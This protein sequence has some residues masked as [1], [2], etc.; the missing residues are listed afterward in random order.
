MNLSMRCLASEAAAVGGADE[1]VCEEEGAEAAAAEEAEAQRGSAR[2]GASSRSVLPA[3]VVALSCLADWCLNLCLF[4]F[5]WLCMISLA[6]DW[7]GTVRYYRYN[8]QCARKST[9][10]GA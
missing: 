8:D 7:G 10:A 5:L 6:A 9:S 3:Q 2:V 1:V 4:P